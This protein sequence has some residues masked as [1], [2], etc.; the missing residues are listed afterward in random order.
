MAFEITT[1]EA[2][3]YVN[4]FR[5]TLGY[6]VNGKVYDYLVESI[7]YAQN[8]INPTD[9]WDFGNSIEDG[10]SQHNSLNDD[11]AIAFL[12]WGYNYDIEFDMC[13]N[14]GE[15]ATRIAENLTDSFGSYVAG[16]LM[17]L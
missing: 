6:D 17:A 12:A 1:A 8:A 3:S 9:A 14:V 7:R 10:L 15:V 2:K 16:Q 4:E 11:E 5:N 13:D